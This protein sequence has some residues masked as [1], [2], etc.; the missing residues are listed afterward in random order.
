MDE[1]TEVF[2]FNGNE[3]EILLTEDVDV[4]FDGDFLMSGKQVASVLGYSDTSDAIRTH[5]DEDDKIL[6]K[7]SNLVNHQLRNLANRGETFITESGVYALI[8]GSKLEKAKEFKH[9]VTKE[10]LPT[11][12]RTGQYDLTKRKTPSYEL[13]D[14]VERAKVWIEEEKERQEL[15]LQN[16]ELRPKTRGNKDSWKENIRNT[17]EQKIYSKY[18]T[19]KNPYE[20]Y[21][22][23]YGNFNNYLYKNYNTTLDDFRR[24]KISESSD[25]KCSIGYLNKLSENVLEGLSIDHEMRTKF[26]EFLA[27][28]VNS[29]DLELKYKSEINE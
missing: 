18:P 16:T 3:M 11:I 27:E 17:I 15:L 20:T 21:N 29:L 22:I 2:E 26:E 24:E 19:I 10:V 9:W 13:E 7:N 25:E 4:E 28:K 12:R 1:L 8:F 23:V 5:I 6:M 14:P